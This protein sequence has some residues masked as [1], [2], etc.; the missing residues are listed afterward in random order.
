MARIEFFV[1]ADSVS[2]D[3]QTNTM[4]VF[5]VLEEI[6]VDNPKPR[7]LL[8]KCVAVALWIRGEDEEPGQ[9]LQQKLTITQPNGESQSFQTNFSFNQSSD[10]HRILNRIQGLP[11]KGV[12]QLRFEIAINGVHAATHTVDVAVK[13]GS[14]SGVLIR[15]PKSAESNDSQDQETSNRSDDGLSPEN[16]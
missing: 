6:H 12:G 3:Q 13:P 5:E 1:V 15:L 4:S 10:R 11:V 14:Q 16:A 8:G 7:V 2:V 9:D